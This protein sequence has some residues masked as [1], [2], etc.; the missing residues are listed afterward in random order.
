MEPLIYSEF[1][2][3]NLEDMLT[4]LGEDDTKKVLSCFSCPRNKDVENFLKDK[5][6]LFSQKDY[7]KTFLVFWEAPKSKFGERKIEFVGY[8]ALTTKSISISRETNVSAMSSEKWR[9]LCRAVNEKTSS[10]KCSLSAYLIGQL[11]KNFTNGN[12][13]LISGKDLLG[14]AIQKIQEAKKLTGGKVVYVECEN[15]AKLLEF[16]ISNKFNVFGERSLDG[17]ETDIEGS[18]L[19]QLFRYID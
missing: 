14:M 9:K 6:I 7:A 8:Y 15:K 13:C 11:G 12:D 18:T 10:K 2:T 19:M 5:A 17:D 1:K 3:I 16:Y 4:E